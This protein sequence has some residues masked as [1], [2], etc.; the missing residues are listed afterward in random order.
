VF[1]SVVGGA[2]VVGGVDVVVVGCVVGVA[3]VDGAVVGGAV[4]VGGGDVVVVGGAVGG[5]VGGVVGGDVWLVWC[6]MK[7]CLCCPCLS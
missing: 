2:I 1:G 4:V 3:V 5:V 6:W 7:A